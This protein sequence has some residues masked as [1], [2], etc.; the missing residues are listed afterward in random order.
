[1]IVKHKRTKK[2]R[3]A[4]EV[5]SYLK[6]CFPGLNLRVECKDEKSLKSKKATLYV[7]DTFFVSWTWTYELEKSL[8]NQGIIVEQE[9]INLIKDSFYV[10]LLSKY[11]PVI[12]P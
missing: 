4:T 2:N 11:P 3:I 12:V 1:M 5:E 6:S 9:I 7:D 8:L 10:D